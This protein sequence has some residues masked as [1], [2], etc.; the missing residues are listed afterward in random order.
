M[1]RGKLSCCGSSLYL[2]NAFGVGYSMVVEKK[3]ATDFNAS[4]MESTVKRFVHE[5]KIISDAGKEMAFQLPLSASGSFPQLF[6]EMDKNLSYLKIQSYGISVTTL[7]E[8][9]LRVSQISEKKEGNNH[10][11]TV[12]R[13]FHN[14]TR[15]Y[16]RCSGGIDKKSRWSGRYYVLHCYRV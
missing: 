8:V 6:S 12:T 11:K 13:I 9:F 5:A 7:E 4:V 15:T 3:S 14:L 1:S 2:K 10:K 16:N